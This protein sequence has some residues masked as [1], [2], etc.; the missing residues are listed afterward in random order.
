MEIYLIVPVIR[1]GDIKKTVFRPTTEKKHAFREE[2]KHIRA[3]SKSIKEDKKQDNE[4][5]RMRR[6]VNAKR[7]LENERKSEVVQVIKNPAKIKRMK[8]KALR[9]IEKRDLST[10]KTV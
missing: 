1:F 9:K 5:K 2:M 6:E 7:R 3:L 10:I 8:K 4:N